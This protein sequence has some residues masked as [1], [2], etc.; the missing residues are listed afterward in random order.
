MTHINNIS[1][2]TKLTFKINYYNSLEIY[3]LLAY[4]K[5]NK[6]I[7]FSSFVQLPFSITMA[8]F[9]GVQTSLAGKPTN[10]H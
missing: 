5:V 4:Q 6:N 7:F 2:K 9:T 1:C 3:D 8:V 10:S